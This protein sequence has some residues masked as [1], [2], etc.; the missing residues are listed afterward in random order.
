VLALIVTSSI[1][2]YLQKNSKHHADSE[3]GYFLLSFGSLD[4]AFFRDIQ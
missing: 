4:V 1:H 3:S 2:I